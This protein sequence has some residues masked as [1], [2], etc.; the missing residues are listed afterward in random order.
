MVLKLVALVK[1]HLDNPFLARLAARTIPTQEGP[2]SGIGQR[3]IHSID[4]LHCRHTPPPLAA[5]V[6][7]RRRECQFC[8][9]STCDNTWIR[10]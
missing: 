6:S 5:P 8:K 9:E 10:L 2:E 7:L 4:G 3:G 1:L